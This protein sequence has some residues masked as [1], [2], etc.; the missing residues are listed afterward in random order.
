MLEI[1]VAAV[2]HDTIIVI[3]LSNGFP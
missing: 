3:D 1:E 2:V